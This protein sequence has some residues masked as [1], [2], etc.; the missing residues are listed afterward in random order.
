MQ[1]RSGYRCYT[2]IY[3]YSCF[4]FYKC[5]VFMGTMYHFMICMYIYIWYTL[6]VFVY[7][8]ISLFCTY[9]IIDLSIYLSIYP[10]FYRQ[11]KV[12]LQYHGLMSMFIRFNPWNDKTGCW[13]GSQNKSARTKNPLGCLIAGYQV[14][15]RFYWAGVWYLFNESQVRIYGQPFEQRWRSPRLRCG[16]LLDVL[17]KGLVL[18]RTHGEIFVFVLH[19]I[20]GLDLWLFFCTSMAQGPILLPSDHRWSWKCVLWG[21]HILGLN[22]QP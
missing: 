4:F 19:P 11:F 7:L 2:C 8:I 12:I 5:D 3:S 10:S 15:S 9:S 13:I 1:Y 16:G 18:G 17:I 22:H 14:R 20:L 21:Y 6:Y